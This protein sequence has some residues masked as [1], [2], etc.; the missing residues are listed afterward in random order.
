MLLNLGDSLSA[1]R[2]LAL[3]VVL[4]SQFPAIVLVRQPDP[5]PV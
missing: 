4:P 5:T 2:W 1:E 3:F